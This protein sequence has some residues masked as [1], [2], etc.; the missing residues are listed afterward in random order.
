[1]A[2]LVTIRHK[3]T[4]RERQVAKSAVGFFP[5]YEVLDKAGRRAASQPTTP[6]KES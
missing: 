2:E 4:Q 1:M 6:S 5:D 3:Q